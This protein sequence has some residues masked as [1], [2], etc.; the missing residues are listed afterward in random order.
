MPIPFQLSVI[1]PH[2]NEPD[3]LRR[4]LVA[5]VSQRSDGI[6]FEIIVVDNGSRAMPHDIC[7]KVVDLTLV[8]EL[9]PGPGP[10]RNLGAK[11]AKAE[12][13]A[14]IDADCVA[15]PGWIAAIFE[16]MAN[17]GRTIFI[18][19][20]IQIQPA[21]A[22][23]LTAV[24]CYERIY[25]YN[26]RAYV[27]QYGF[28]A[29]G[30]MAVWKQ[31]FQTVGP[32]GG[33][34]TMEDTDWGQRATRAGYKAIFL[35]AALVVTP[36]CKSFPELARRWDRHIAH[37]FRDV[38]HGGS[39]ATIKWLLRAMII[40]ASTVAEILNILVTDRVLGPRNRL[41][42][43]CCLARVRLHRTWR[44]LVLAVDGDASRLV[45]TWNRNDS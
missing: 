8:R 21:D 40:A 13:L 36:S 20:D 22:R 19:G 7:A 42:A 10:A 1:I 5:L 37:E 35:P 43:F 25:S 45:K 18:G 38:I 15:Q 29:T 24:E 2:L 26:A 17:R 14:F 9:T 16:T 44:M 41:L 4:C 34:A 32:F 3:D 31:I 33:I 12:L 11:M 27:E 6:S 30:N 23:R 28:A 39:G